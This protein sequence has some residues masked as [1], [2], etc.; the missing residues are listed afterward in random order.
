MYVI[1]GAQR[2]VRIYGSKH[3]FYAAFVT[4]VFALNV[5]S[6]VSLH[7]EYKTISIQLCRGLQKCKKFDIIYY[8]AQN[9]DCG[10]VISK[11]TPF[12]R[13]LAIMNTKQ[14]RKFWRKIDV[15]R[16][17]S[18]AEF[19]NDYLSSHAY[20]SKTNPVTKDFIATYM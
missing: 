3:H 15:T 10:H 5:N 17:M 4:S 9:I 7:S 8:F 2:N 18:R 6:S 13:Q 1:E 14:C 19:S 12:P 16:K 11:K 20:S